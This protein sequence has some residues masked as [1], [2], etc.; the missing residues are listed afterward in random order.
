MVNLTTRRS[1]FLSFALTAGRPTAFFFFG[2]QKLL[3]IYGIR[4]LC[5]M[6]YPRKNKQARA[7]VIRCLVEGCSQ[8]STTRITGCAQ[9][10]VKRIQQETGEACSKYQHE[11]FYN[12]PCVRFQLDEI[13]SFAGCRG[14][15]KQNAKN[16][17]PGDVWTWVALCPDTKLVP[18]WLTIN[19]RTEDS[20]CNLCEDLAARIPENAR[21][22]ITS[23]GLRAYLPAIA[24]NFDNVDYGQVV[25]KYGRNKHGFETCVGI[26]KRAVSG[27]PDMDHVSTS[28]IER[29]NLTIRMGARRYTRKTNAFSKRLRNH[30]HAT[31][32]HFLYYNLVR[33]HKTLK[34]TPAEAAGVTDH[35]LTIED[36]VE[37]TDQYLAEKEVNQYEQAFADY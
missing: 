17:H 16:D 6:P 7:A 2:I 8:N 24:K 9:N 30:Q 20:A 36:V 31:A 14:K 10:T 27:D 33:K 19:D 12:L 35:P 22:Q 13:W 1:D 29:Q 34:K 25:K 37:I 26:E 11:L 21:V 4:L 28:L 5:Q 18:T 3:T 32:I 15:N 23:D